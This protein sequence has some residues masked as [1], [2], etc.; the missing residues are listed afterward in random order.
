[1]KRVVT[2]SM[3]MG[4][5]IFLALILVLFTCQEARAGTWVK[6]GTTFDPGTYLICDVVD[7]IPTT[8]LLTTYEGTM[9]EIDDYIKLFN[10]EP[11]A[12]PGFPGWYRWVNG[13]WIRY[14]VPWRYIEGEIM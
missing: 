9:E 11:K 7:N 4:V 6:I 1:M 10:R 8:C 14:K 13:Y 12:K 2:I 5:L 3:V